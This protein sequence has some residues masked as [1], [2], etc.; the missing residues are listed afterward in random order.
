MYL[1]S[2]L[3]LRLE[4]PARNNNPLQ[5]RQLRQDECLEIAGV[6]IAD[7]LLQ[8][9]HQP[10]LPGSVP[11]DLSPFRVVTRERVV[12]RET[13]PVSS[14][15]RL[16]Q[17]QAA[18]RPSPCPSSIT[19][20]FKNP[21]HIPHCGPV[22]LRASTDVTGVTWS[23]E[24][25][26]A[27]VDPNSKI[28]DNGTITLAFTQPTGEI[29]ARATGPTGC[30]IDKTFYISS[31]P[32]AIKQ[33][34][35]LHAADPG[36]YGAQFQHVFYSADGNFKSLAGV[37]VGERF[38]DVPNPTAK[39]HKLEAPLNPFGTVTFHTIATLTPNATNNFSLDANG[40]FGSSGS[41]PNPGDSVRT[42]EVGINVG[43]FIKTFSNSKPSRGLPAGYTLTQSLYWFCPQM[44]EGGDKRWTR[45]VKAA[46][47]RTLREVTGKLEFVTTVNGLEVVD[48]YT[49]PTGVSN[50]KATPVTTPHSPIAPPGG[51]GVVA[52]ARSVKLSADS[53]PKT[54]PMGQ[55]LTWTIEGKDLGCKVNPD[56]DSH[57]A[58]M[59][60]GTVA[61]TVT[62]QVCR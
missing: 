44:P 43:R 37:A 53:L 47:S 26:E 50:L 14:N 41:Y 29:Y 42:S 7:S 56:K 18:A 16:L 57:F 51:G 34:S 1:G 25:G 11:A 2:D 22:A 4:H 33:T 8:M 23:L 60:V 28:A 13:I 48:Q 30:K 49:G 21:A 39:F 24:K 17:R 58:T 12:A 59:T 40:E 27:A 19:F 62:I 10:P 20:N 36:Y 5:V 15:S 45:F 46:H 32:V 55:D 38:N 31:H 52:A 9:P 35:K 3:G 54:L 61:G 6:R